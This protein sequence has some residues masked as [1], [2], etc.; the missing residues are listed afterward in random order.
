MSDNIIRGVY[1]V[2]EPSLHQDTNAL[3]RACEEA[4]KGGIRWLQYR[5]KQASFQEKLAI[6]NALQAL[7]AD[8]KV[9]L[10]INDDMELALQV[11]AAGVHLGQGDGSAADART[12]LG[13][14][15]IIGVTCHHDLALAEQAIDDGANYVA[16]GRFFTSATKPQAP[17][18]PLA[19]LSEARQTFQR[20][21]I[22]AIGGID[23]TNVSH[24]IHAGAHMIAVAHNLFA[25]TNITAQAQKLAA[26]IQT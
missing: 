2:T 25:A 23:E 10:I 13:P 17:A 12:L 7:A 6:A 1:A 9:P 4:M 20:T 24:T 3:V 21:T 26:L 8:Y 16:F 19:V 5:H 11:G 15:A 14:C 22:V 18:A